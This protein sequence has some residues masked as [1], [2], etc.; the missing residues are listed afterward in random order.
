MPIH[1]PDGTEVTQETFDAVRDALHGFRSGI[2]EELFHLDGMN[3]NL[4]AYHRRQLENIREHMDHNTPK[5][6]RHNDNE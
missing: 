3:T 6:W 2:R 5:C 1:W 4:T